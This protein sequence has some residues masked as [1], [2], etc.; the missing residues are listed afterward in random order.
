MNPVSEIK[1]F[2]LEVLDCF[3]ELAIPELTPITSKIWGFLYKRTQGIILKKPDE[4]LNQKLLKIY[5]IL[6]PRFKDIDIS[7]QINAAEQLGSVPIPNVGELAQKK[8]LVVISE[9]EA[10]KIIE[11]LEL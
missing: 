3:N 9:K 4:E 1:K 5:K 8:K 6:H 7:I 10:F 2:S 11:D